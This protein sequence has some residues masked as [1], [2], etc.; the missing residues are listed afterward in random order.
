MFVALLQLF[1]LLEWGG[2]KGFVL[3]PMLNTGRATGI[4]DSEYLNARYKDYTSL[5]EQ[6][7]SN[8]APSKI[9]CQ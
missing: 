1:E 6:R 4:L 9:K 8:D 3:P 7:M 5:L 2:G